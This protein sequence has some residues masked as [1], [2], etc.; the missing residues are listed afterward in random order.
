[1]ATTNPGFPV[2]GGWG[3]RRPTPVLFSENKCED[4]RIGVEGAPPGS[5]KGIIW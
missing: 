3:L 4:E 5:A 1:M 2:G